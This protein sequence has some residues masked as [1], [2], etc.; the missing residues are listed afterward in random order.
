MSEPVS[1]EELAEHLDVSP[2]RITVATREEEWVRRQ[3]PVG[4]W[5]VYDEDGQLVGYEVPEVARR[6]LGIGEAVEDRKNGWFD[7]LLR[8][9]VGGDR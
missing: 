9:I 1:R 6:K 7:R 8:V 2:R 4:D 3:Y 5:A